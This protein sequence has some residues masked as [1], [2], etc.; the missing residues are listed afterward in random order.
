MYLLPQERRLDYMPSQRCLAL[1]ILVQKHRS[2][3]KF[4]QTETPGRKGGL[5]VMLRQV[6]SSSIF[7]YI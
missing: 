4:R 2:S 3:C 6:T 1:R 5:T 7:I